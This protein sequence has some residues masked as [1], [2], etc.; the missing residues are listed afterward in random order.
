MQISRWVGAQNRRLHRF[1]TVLTIED[2]LGVVV[3]NEMSENRGSDYCQKAA[4]D[5]GKTAHR[6]F[7]LPDFHRFGRAYG[8]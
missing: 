5:Y 4:Y 1:R 2:G 6:S 3:L 8:M 7:Y